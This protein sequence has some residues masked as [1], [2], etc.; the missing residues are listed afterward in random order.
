LDFV[1][2]FACVE[3]WDYQS[4][5]VGINISPDAFIASVG[6]ACRNGLE[7]SALFS[8]PYG[9]AISPYMIYALVAD[10]EVIRQIAITTASVTTFAGSSA[11]ST[12]IAN[13]SQLIA[14]LRWLSPEM[15]SLHWLIR[16]IAIATASNTTGAVGGRFK[17]RLLIFTS[18]PFPDE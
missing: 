3:G 2:T 11:G 13:Q 12:H 17:V 4:F 5:R 8:N 7:T 16:N 9:V 14:L 10:T 18:L 6:I 1:T 15:E